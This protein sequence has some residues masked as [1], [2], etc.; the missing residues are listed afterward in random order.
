MPRQ[1]HFI[2]ERNLVLNIWRCSG[3]SRG[4]DINL[5]IGWWR[6]RSGSAP[7]RFYPVADLELFSYPISGLLIVSDRVAGFATIFLLTVL[8]S[9]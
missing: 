1:S 4:V 8:F 5:I 6:Y 2:L 9:D 3:L 7:G